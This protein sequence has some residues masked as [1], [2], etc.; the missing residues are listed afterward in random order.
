[1]PR[2]S[3]LLKVTSPSV[4]CPGNKIFRAILLRHWDGTLTR[5]FF[6]TR[7][8][9]GDDLIRLEKD[10]RLKIYKKL[11]STVYEPLGSQTKWIFF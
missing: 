4:S 7:G 11:S 10:A 5:Y 8:G 3:T 6:K 9:G 2:E 1:M